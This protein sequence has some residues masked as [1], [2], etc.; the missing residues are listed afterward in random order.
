MMNNKDDYSEEV[1]EIMGQ[2]ANWMVRW[3]AALLVLI[4]AVVICV[5]FLITYPVFV[6][7][8]FR[9]EAT[10]GV[11]SAEGVTCEAVVSESVYDQ[12]EVGQ[13][14]Q[15]LVTAMANR[16]VIGRVNAKSDGRKVQ[17]VFPVEADQQKQLRTALQRAGSAKIK[18][19]EK[20]L[21]AQFTGIFLP[22]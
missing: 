6:K 21:I 22:K 10:T 20:R 13:E 16:A 12:I 5:F 1:N 15:V 18:T 14:V 17:L 19:G 7:V 3:G 11:L 2:R 4:V 9:I 8:P